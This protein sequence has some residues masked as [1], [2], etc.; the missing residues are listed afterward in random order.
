MEFKS[1]IYQKTDHAAVV[2]INRPNKLN[3][4]DAEI[5]QELASALDMAEAD[6]HISAVVI[7]GAGEKAFVAG[8]DITKLKELTV[9]TAK[10]FSEQG[11][12]LFNRIEKFKKPIIA[13]VN[14]Y[15]LGGGSELAWACH[16]RIAS[17]QAKFGQPEVNLGIIPGYGGTQRLV[18]LVGRG[19]ATELIATGDPVDAA[20][21]YEMHLVNKVVEPGELMPT[22]L[23]LVESIS[24]RAPFAVRL[25]LQAIDAAVQL[26]QDEGMKIEAQLFALSCGTTDQKEGITAFLEKRKPVWKGA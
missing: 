18:R 9:I 5:M 14:G 24:Q 21:A 22:A 20:T 8:A 17:K 12:A 25:A 6:K 13:A 2:T 26:P 3:A 10:D 1:I 7:T 19:I 16:I 23:K 4:L 11:Q 15:A